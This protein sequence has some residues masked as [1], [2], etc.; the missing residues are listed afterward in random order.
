MT[1]LEHI[2]TAP[3]LDLTPGDLDTILAE[4][5][6][7]H[8]IFSP[9]FR[10]PE[11]R[12]WSQAYLHGLLLEI[13]RKSIEPM[14]LHLRGADR[15]AVRA[16][17]QFLGDGAWDDRAILQRLWQEL[18]ADLG[19]DDGVLILDGSD[20]PKQGHE[21]VGV[22]RQYCGELGKTAN[23]QA[24]VFLSY[25]SQ[26]GY[27]MLDRCLYVPEV[28]FTDAYAERRMACGVPH[29]LTFATKSE[30]GWAMIETVAQAGPVPC[31][32]VTCD[33]G[34]GKNPELLDQIASLGLWYL[35]EVPHDTRVWR[36]RPVTVLP[37]WSRRGPKPKRER[38]AP[39]AAAPEEVQAIA[40]S[41]PAEQWQRHVIQEGSQG[42][43]LAEFAFVR[44]IA[45]RDTLPGPEVWLVLRRSLRDGKLKTYVSNAPA[46]IAEQ[47]LVR[48]SGMRWPIE[49]CFE[50]GKQELGMGD[51]EVRSWRGW[52]HHMTLV[53][54]ALA[55]LVR[56]QG[57]FEKT[58]Q[59]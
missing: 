55:F 38:V 12:A 35:A 40:V 47:R 3:G 43:Q 23:C 21:S 48:T 33:E 52:H 22:A 29:D 18:A 4:L 28:W 7:F 31:R 26:H 14:V 27:A 30:L 42:P 45:V 51:Y 10:R 41:L 11:Q 59:R 39:E 24:G 58:L 6:A 25:A 1:Q 16:M 34:F 20:F 8:A 5:R 15:N 44:V 46:E 56:L 53:M 2:T 17:Q 57:R 36:E 50:V 32:W 19:D 9:L 54:L 37:A 13:P 49:T